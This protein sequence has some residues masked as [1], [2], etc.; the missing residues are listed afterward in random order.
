M[1]DVPN[2]KKILTLVFVYI[3]GVTG[4]FLFH[5]RSIEEGYSWSLFGQCLLMGLGFPISYLVIKD[6]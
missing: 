4:I 2:K 5:P 6:Q 3:V 1:K